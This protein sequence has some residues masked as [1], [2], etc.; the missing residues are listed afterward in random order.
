MNDATRQ[1]HKVSLDKYTSHICLNGHCY[2]YYW[3][4]LQIMAL[5][6]S[7]SSDGSGYSWQETDDIESFHNWYVNKKCI[8]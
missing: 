4:A 8:R 3:V 5:F 2:P 7:E 6:D 1:S